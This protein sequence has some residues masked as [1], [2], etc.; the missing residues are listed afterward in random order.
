MGTI[1]NTGT[2]C[3]QYADYTALSTTMEKGKSYQITVTNCEGF[4]DYDWC[5]VW[6]DWNQDEDFYDDGETLEISGDYYIF[7]GTITPPVDALEGDTRMRVRIRYT[8]FGEPLEPCGPTT[9]GEVEDYTITVTAATTG[10]IRGMKFHDVD[11]DGINESNEPGLE[12]WKIY[13]DENGNDSWD[14]GERYD[15]TDLNGGYEFAGLL[16]GSYIIVEINQPDWKQTFPAGDGSH[17][18]DVTAGNTVENIDFGNSPISCGSAWGG[19]DE[20]GDVDIEDMAILCEQ[21]LMERL[22]ADIV[23]YCPDGVVNFSDW[24]EFA[25]AWQST[26]SSPNWNVR[27]DISP[28]GGNEIVD[29]NDLTVLFGEWLTLG[30]YCGDIAPVP[31]GDGVVDVFDFVALAQNWVD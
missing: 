5:G 13:I 19:L 27:C 9:Y 22:L 12:G 7:T 30:A 31:S 16:P 11:G 20:D 15:I 6:V 29:W 21:W 25:A 1:V 17:L 4:F 14:E 28:Q 24:V 8:G 3:H 2:G 26:P 23:P 10:N 18:V